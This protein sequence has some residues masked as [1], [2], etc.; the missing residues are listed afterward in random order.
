MMTQADSEHHVVQSAYI[1]GTV[2]LTD[3]LDRLKFASQLRYST[4]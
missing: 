4:R 1:D 3:M 2:T